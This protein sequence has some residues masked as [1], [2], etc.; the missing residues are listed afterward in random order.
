[1]EHRYQKIFVLSQGTVRWSVA[2]HT[3]SCG[4][5]C[6][7]RGKKN[8][9]GTSQVLPWLGEGDFA[10]VTRQR[11]KDERQGEAGAIPRMPVHSGDHVDL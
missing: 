6:L 7:Q 5:D 4:L 3:P 2:P 8:F 11:R 10:A 1:M 9:H